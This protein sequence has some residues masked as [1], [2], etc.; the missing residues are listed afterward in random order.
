ME[1]FR[2]LRKG[3]MLWFRNHILS[4][5]RHP[6]SYEWTMS[7]RGR[8]FWLSSVSDIKMLQHY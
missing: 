6:V 5:K 4:F 7:G 2:H 3:G 8:G 1:E